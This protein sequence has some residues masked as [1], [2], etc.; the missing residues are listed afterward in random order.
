MRTINNIYKIRF[1]YPVDV[2]KSWAFF[3]L[4]CSYRLRGVSIKCNTKL[5]F[6]LCS[7][8]L[9][10]FFYVVAIERIE[11]GGIDNI[12]NVKDNLLKMN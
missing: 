3:L 9:D 11:K 12:R 1:K 7:Y 5:D 10:R 4:P 6:A 2:A 8:L